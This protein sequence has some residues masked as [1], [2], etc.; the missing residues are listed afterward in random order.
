[1]SKLRV[2][3]Y[4]DHILDSYEKICAYSDGLDAVEFLSD[5][6]SINRDAIARHLEIIGEASNNIAKTI[7]KM[8]DHDSQ[9]KEL[10][11]TKAIITSELQN[12]LS[13][14]YG[15]RNV[16][17][18]GYITVDWQLVWV[19][20]TDHLPAFIQNIQQAQDAFTLR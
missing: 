2:I 5:D 14:A 12:E 19:T 9:S 3:D 8:I 13:M 6:R 10:A 20:I 4:L 16:L 18:H 11:N 15:M 7:Q 1:M 17:S